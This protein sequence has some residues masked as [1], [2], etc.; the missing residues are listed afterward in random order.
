[1]YLVDSLAGE[2]I[3][4][5]DTLPNNPWRNSIMETPPVLPNPC[6]VDFRYTNACLMLFLDGHTGTQAVFVNLAEVER[7]GVKVRNLDQN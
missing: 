4:P 1:M 3:E 5:D 2:T 6:E 7:R